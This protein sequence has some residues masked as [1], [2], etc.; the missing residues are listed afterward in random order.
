MKIRKGIAAV[1]AA[2]LSLSVLMAAPAQAS[3]TIRGSG[4]S[5]LGNL[6][7]DVCVPGYQ[8][9]T[10]NV[11]N[12]RATGSGTGRREFT[13]NVV[14]FAFSDTPYAASEAQPDNFVHI[15][16]AAFPIAVFANLPGYNG[17]LNLRPDTVAKIYAGQITMWNDKQIV[18]DNNRTVKT[19]IYK[20]RTVN[21]KKVNVLNKKGKPVVARVVTKTVKANLPALPIRVWYRA[22]S[23]G[24]TGVYM[25]WLTGVAPSIWDPKVAGNN[26]FTAA[27]SA[28]QGKAVPANFQG[29]PQSVGVANGV[30][31]IPGS[32]G[33][34]ELSFATERN[35]K[36]AAIQNGAG[37]FV[38]PSGTSASA[39]LGDFV[40]EGNRGIVKLNPLSKASGAYSLA[41]FAYA[42]GYTSGKDA[43]K[44]KTVVDFYNYVL[45][46]CIDA[47]GDKLG[48]IKISGKL[49]DQA[50]KQIAMVK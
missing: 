37:E 48:F 14:D 4:A 12:Y 38:L 20:T 47:G 2:S 9:K 25:N 39:F 30:A 36:V 21:G 28:T 27:Y 50:R 31:S 43:E 42:V 35:L 17:A 19:P 33:Y 34:A 11:V 23:S 46:E 18:A 26:V 3:T 15:P 24:T 7:L 13:N 22:D 16:I 32:I 8:R 5:S 44:Q 29:G 41:V 45:G 10:G 1:A 49:L 6:I 40:E